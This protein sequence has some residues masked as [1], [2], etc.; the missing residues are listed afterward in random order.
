MK[1]FWLLIVVLLA[2]MPCLTSA[3]SAPQ[4]VPELRVYKSGFAVGENIEFFLGIK[5]LTEAQTKL[6][7]QVGETG[8]LEITTPD[9]KLT[10]QKVGLRY[11]GL[12]SGY[13]LGTNWIPK[14]NV[15]V[16][17]YTLL[18]RYAGQQTP[19]VTVTVADLPI[20]KK[21]SATLRLDS[22]MGFPQSLATTHATLTVKNNTDQTIRF[23][24]LSAMAGL[25]FSVRV[26]QGAWRIAPSIPS[27]RRHADRT[28]GSISMSSPG[29]RQKRCP[30]WCSIPAKRSSSRSPWSRRAPPTSTPTKK[31][32]RCRQASTK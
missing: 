27:G 6:R 23:P 2:L 4:G 15:V 26:K 13:I 8:Q 24:H 9:G 1:K 11:S 21:I 30:P 32:C 14:Q 22:S 5:G 20:L 12:H 10:T 7:G 19:P 18:F 31:R 17:R 28:R 3:K 16:G 29:R 25:S